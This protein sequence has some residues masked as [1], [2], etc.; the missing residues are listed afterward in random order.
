LADGGVYFAGDTGL[1]Y[2]MTLIGEAGIDLAVLPIGDNFTMGPD[3]AL[4]AVK[5]LSPKRVLPA[6][7]NTWPI[8]GA[9]AHAWADRVTAATSAQVIVARPGDT[10]TL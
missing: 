4:R 3:D 8:I 2:D 5:L 10:V 1:F 7:Y 6:H 9:D